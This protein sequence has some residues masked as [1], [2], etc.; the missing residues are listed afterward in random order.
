LRGEI[1]KILKTEGEAKQR[2][3]EAEKEARAIVEE[4]GAKRAG[5]ADAKKEEARKQARD[6]ALRA[7]NEAKNDRDRIIA[8]AEKRARNIVASA[9][10]HD[11]PFIDAAIKQI[12]GLKP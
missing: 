6:L 3:A 7:A 10:L 11:Y 5:L 8:E 1:E 4:A 9:D 2:I 12:A